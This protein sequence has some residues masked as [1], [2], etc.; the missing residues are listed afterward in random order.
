MPW[1][2]QRDA[3]ISI[4]IIAFVSFILGASVSSSN[5]SAQENT[6]PVSSADPSLTPSASEDPAKPIN[7][8][9]AGQT[10]TEKFELKAGLATAKLTHAGEGH[11][12]AWLMNQNGE[13]LELLANDSGQPFNGS[14][15]FRV[16]STGQYLLDISA[17]AAWTIDI[18]Q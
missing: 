10:A 9:G 1:Y 17:D 3:I 13:K 15:A 6:S 8:S 5:N 14:R 2:K 11:F 18:T 7:L 12:S 4:V 16:P